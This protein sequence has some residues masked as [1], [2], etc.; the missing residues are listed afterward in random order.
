MIAP[1]AQRI[2]PV[3]EVLNL[4]RHADLCGFL[5]LGSA[6]TRPVGSGT[7]YRRMER[8]GLY[9]LIMMKGSPRADDGGKT[10]FEFVEPPKSVATDAAK[11]PGALRRLSGAQQWL[12][13]SSGMAVTLG[14]S[15]Y[16]RITPG[17]MQSFLCSKQSLR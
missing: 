14:F 11:G 7:R 17:D 9:V 8:R 10:S 3:N 5:L 12:F 6:V 15:C 13:G 16:H 1:G 2:R 4:A